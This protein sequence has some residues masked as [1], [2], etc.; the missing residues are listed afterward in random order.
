M[1]YSVTLEPRFADYNESLNALLLKAQAGQ[2]YLNQEVTIDK[3]SNLLIA[4]YFFSL[5]GDFQSQIMVAAVHT[6]TP[7]TKERTY[8]TIEFL[9][10]EDDDESAGIPSY[11]VALSNIEYYYGKNRDKVGTLYKESNGSILFKVDALSDLDHD[12]G[13]IAH[14]KK[15]APLSRY[16]EDTIRAVY[17]SVLKSVIKGFYFDAAEHGGVQTEVFFN[18]VTEIVNRVRPRTFSVLVPMISGLLK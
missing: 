14:A 15:L 5:N 1:I 3:D 12:V 13:W 16:N 10:K 11:K 8:E 6:E 9:N 4:R 2:N 18:V 7:A 17:T